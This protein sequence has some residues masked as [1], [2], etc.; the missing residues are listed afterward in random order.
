[1]TLRALLWFLSFAAGRVLRVTTLAA[2]RGWEFPY[3]L[4]GACAGFVGGCLLLA[5]LVSGRNFLTYWRDPPY[6]VCRR[7]RCR[8]FNYRSVASS[9]AGTI[10]RCRCGDEYVLTGNQFLEV[11]PDQ[12]RR[13]YQYRPPFGR[14]MEVRDGR[15]S[16]AR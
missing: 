9:P 3:H 12:T 6:P 11:L 1:M 2:R 5:L 13:P 4:L 16:A 7:G 10:V 14:W 15:V 8:W